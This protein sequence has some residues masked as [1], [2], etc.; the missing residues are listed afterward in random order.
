MEALCCSEMLVIFYQTTR[1]H[2]TLQSHYSENFKSHVFSS[3]FTFPWYCCMQK[4]EMCTE[5]QQSNCILVGHNRF[6]TE[7]SGVMDYR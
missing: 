7:D 2:I 4:Q 6:R 5:I 3:D 1:R